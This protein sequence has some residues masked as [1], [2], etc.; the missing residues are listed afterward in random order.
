MVRS[1]FSSKQKFI[2]AGKERTQP[3]L[4][5]VFIAEFASPKISKTSAQSVGF[6][7]RGSLAP[8]RSKKS[9]KYEC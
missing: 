7:D 3:S 2:V 8:T 9:E 6:W 4:S 5:R 1:T